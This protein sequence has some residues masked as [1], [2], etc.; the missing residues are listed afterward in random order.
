MTFSLVS[1]V[2]QDGD[3]IPR[4]H[5]RRGGNL[6][7]PLAWSDA[8]HGTRSFALVVEDSD[9]PSG[10]FRHWALY[11]IG[12]ER[13]SLAGGV[14]PERE[15]AMGHAANDFG[16]L[17]YEGPQ[18]PKGDRRHRYRFRLAALDV[19]RLELPAR[20]TAEQVWEAAQGH[21]LAEAK[22]VGTFEALP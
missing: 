14:T 9:A 8:P 17:G 7:P 21:L 10:T 13:D 2:F 1:P 15:R 22:L 3:E 5:A 4:S 11:D 19:A 6:S 20:P 16:S 18:P 12:P